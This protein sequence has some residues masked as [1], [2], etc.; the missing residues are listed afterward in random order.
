M[1]PMP[2]GMPPVAGLSSLGSS[3]TTA[4]VVV[5]NDDTLHK[6]KTSLAYQPKR[7]SG[8]NTEESVSRKQKL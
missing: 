1:P 6:Q 8:L 3:A 7:H 5:N 4:S 2:P